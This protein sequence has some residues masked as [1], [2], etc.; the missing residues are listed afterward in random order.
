MGMQRLFTIDH[1]MV[2]KII[3]EIT[4]D[5][6]EALR[7]DNS[8]SRDFMK[9]VNLNGHDTIIPTECGLPVFFHHMNPLIISGQASVNVNFKDMT[10]GE[11]GLTLK[12]AKCIA[13]LIAIVPGEL[14]SGAIRAWLSN[15]IPDWKNFRFSPMGNI[16]A[17]I[18]VP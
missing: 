8:L 2:E 17:S 11:A 15:H 7:K 5:S 12:P 10:T 3:G 1:K 13:I 18:K 6:I 9:I 4:R 14:N 16:S